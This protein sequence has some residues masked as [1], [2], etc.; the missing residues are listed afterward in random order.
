MPLRYAIPAP[1]VGDGLPHCGA[2]ADQGFG[3]S[4]GQC[5]CFRIDPDW[6]ERDGERLQSGAAGSGCGHDPVAVGS[7]DLVGEADR[8][9][10]QMQPRQGNPIQHRQ[11]VQRRAVRSGELMY[12]RLIGE[13]EVPGV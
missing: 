4:S 3:G 12:G 5:E 8:L 6:P 1:D 2:Q 11:R 10:G 9:H 13:G 7:V